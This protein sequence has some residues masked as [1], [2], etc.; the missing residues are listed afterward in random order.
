VPKTGGIFAS[1]VKDEAAGEVILKLVN[2]TASERDFA[3]N[4]EG[5]EMVKPGAKGVLLA[6]ENLTDVN[7]FQNPGRVSPRALPVSI[8]SPE[9][10][11]PV[12]ANAFLVLRVPVQ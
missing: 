9:F 8:T 11:Q 10:T 6:G 2:A 4:L 12:P 3:V 7:D 5:V 1:A